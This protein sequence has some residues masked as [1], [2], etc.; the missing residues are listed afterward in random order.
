MKLL[1]RL[2]ETFRQVTSQAGP[3][4]LAFKLCCSKLSGEQR[5]TSVNEPF[6]TF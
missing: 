2:E 4:S 3:K 1:Y 5:T 6:A